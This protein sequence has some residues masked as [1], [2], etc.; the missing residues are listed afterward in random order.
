MLEITEK[1]REAESSEVKSLKWSEKS[2]LTWSVAKCNKVKWSEVNKQSEVEWG[3]VKCSIEK[4]G[5]GNEFLWKMFIGVVSD[6]K[7]K[8]GVKAWVN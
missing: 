7:W 4:R 6:E 5:G 2:Y 3:E 1:C 8:T